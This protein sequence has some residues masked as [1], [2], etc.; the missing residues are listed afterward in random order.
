MTLYVLLL[1][2]AMLCMLPFKGLNLVESMHMRH[3]HTKGVI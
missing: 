1:G 2:I 3:R